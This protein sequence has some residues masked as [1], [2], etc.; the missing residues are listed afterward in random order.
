VEFATQVFFALAGNPF[1]CPSKDEMTMK[2]KIQTVG[3]GVM[4]IST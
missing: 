2:F 4:Y 1:G 3:G